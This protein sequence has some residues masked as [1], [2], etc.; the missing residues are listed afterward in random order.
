MTVSC[1]TKEA[2]NGEEMQSSANVIL[3]VWTKCFVRNS[4]VKV[5]K[6]ADLENS[7]SATKSGGLLLLPNL[8]RNTMSLGKLE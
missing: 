5:A 8:N 7:Y 6:A 1:P 3:I 2:K 4:S